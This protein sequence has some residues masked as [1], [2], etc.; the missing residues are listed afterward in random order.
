M[1]ST[2]SVLGTLFLQTNES[3]AIAF[4][5]EFPGALRAYGI[6]LHADQLSLRSTYNSS[7][8]PYRLFNLDVA[9]YE[10]DSPMALYGAIPLLYGHGFV[11]F[12]FQITRFPLQQKP[13]QKLNTKGSVYYS[14]T[15]LPS[16][17]II[18]S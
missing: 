5:V 15:K 3:R 18:R 1:Q 2:Q 10:L 6:P 14:V 4:L 7:S 8:D 16:Y 13:K 17:S 12:H 11:A 9:Y